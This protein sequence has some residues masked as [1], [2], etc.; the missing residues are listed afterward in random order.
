MSDKS[1]C[2]AVI[3]R[4]W[5]F[6]AALLM[7]LCPMIGRAQS[8]VQT[9]F[10]PT[11]EQ[12]L[13]AR[14]APAKVTTEAASALSSK[15]Y[16]MIGSISAS[17]PG[18]MASAEVTQRLDAAIVSKAGEAGGDVVRFDREGALGS[19][20]AETGSKKGSCL[21]TQTRY[22]WHRDD[23]GVRNGP[24]FSVC[25]ESANV[26]I[27][28]L[29]PILISEGTVWRNDPKLAAYFA[30]PDESRPC[31]PP[32]PST[33]RA[34]NLWDAVRRE[35]VEAVEAFLQAGA[36]ING[37]DDS[38]YFSHP[39]ALSLA[40]D[41][42]NVAIA[43]VLLDHGAE[44]NAMNNDF[45]HPYTP[46][47]EALGSDVSLGCKAPMV[48]FLFEH[49]AIVDVGG[50][51]TVSKHGEIGLVSDLLAAHVADI[52]RQDKNGQTGLMHAALRCNEDVVKVLLGW[53]AD[54]GMKDK[55]GRTAADLAKDATKR[56][57]N[58]TGSP[59][60][61]YNHHKKDFDAFL[62]LLN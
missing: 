62:T 12:K 8:D 56:S 17:L 14:S 23:T 53:G 4:A 45:E 7:L 54:K 42:E 15:G 58:Y 37:F 49:G 9:L 6:G 40:A 47:L 13:D 1:K 31:L 3:I 33:V 50:A 25:D 27:Y 52:N 19:T 22:V 18:D 43:K 41:K 16:V 24:A 46:I 59:C 57:K 10:K 51:V 36:P 21:K 48:R 55:E 60:Y 2:R 11:V 38:S 29:V 20:L 26:P 44:V 30:L 28:G 5:Q 61:S 39:T 32:V 34:E 35:Q